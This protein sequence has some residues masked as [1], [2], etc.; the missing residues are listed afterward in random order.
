MVWILDSVDP[1]S[2]PEGSYQIR[3]VLDEK[4]LGG[5]LP[6][7]LASSP[8][9]VVVAPSPATPSPGAAQ[10]KC[11]AIMSASAWKSDAAKALATAAAYLAEH[12]K[13][14]AVLF[15]QGKI[16]RSQGRKL[17]A[18]ASFEAALMAA[19]ENKEAMAENFAIQRVIGDLQR[20]LAAK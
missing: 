6:A 8:I 1:G 5:A 4:K 12:P 16:Q 15:L 14:V 18:L 13:D 2:L 11:L 20:E 7:G 3:A 17:E 10:R 19:E 9:V